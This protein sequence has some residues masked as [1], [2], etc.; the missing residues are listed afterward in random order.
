MPELYT[1][2]QRHGG[3]NFRIYLGWMFMAAS[4]AMI[5]YF[6]MWG[7]YGKALFTR[8]QSLYPLGDMT[9]TAC[10][11]V[12]ATKLQLIE[13]R[14]RTYMALIG[15]FL[16]VG[17]WFMWN[18]IL[19]GTYSSTTNPEYY[20]KG[21]LYTGFGRNL[22]WWLTLLLAVVVCLLFEI[23]VRVLKNTFFPTDV[24]IF[25]TLESDLGVRKRFEE[26]SAAWLQAGWHRGTKKSSMEL[27]REAEAQAQREDEVQEL[28]NRPRVMEEGRSTKSGV[29]TEE[30]PVMIDDGPGRP[31]TDIHDMLSR[32][33]GSVRQEDLAQAIERAAR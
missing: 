3:F 24:E 23:G 5:I 18:I 30:M 21:G 22:L 7:L 1:K 2:G 15:W 29:Q 11:I 8:D 14:N 17:G 28:L 32:R 16:A 25:Q 33:F 20:V 26:A 9:F 12:I 6:T 19:A 31:S 27:Q 4:E 13:Q 10:V